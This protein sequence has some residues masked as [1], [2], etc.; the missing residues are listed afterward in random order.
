MSS[1]EKLRKIKAFIFDVDGVMTDGGILVTEEGQLLRKMHVR[2]GLAMKLA[3]NAGYH[4]AI[5]TG[6]SSQGVEN[7]LRA[8]GIEDIYL[9]AHNKWPVFEAHVQKHSLNLSEILY[10]GDDLPDLPVIKSVGVGAAPSDAAEEVLTAADYISSVAGGKGCVR[11]V[12]EKI[13]RLN[14]Q[15]KI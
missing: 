10:M 8:L 2:D 13:M 6:G 15:W 4:M 12:I 7:R 9:R 3:L 1:L 5:I 11:D 14:H